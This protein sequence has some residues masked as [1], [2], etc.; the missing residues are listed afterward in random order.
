MKNLNFKAVLEKTREVQGESTLVD[1]IKDVAGKQIS[2]KD[3]E[4]T[5]RNSLLLP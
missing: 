1:I 2:V 4:K 3:S 5:G